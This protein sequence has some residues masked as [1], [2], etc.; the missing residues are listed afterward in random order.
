MDMQKKLELGEI[1]QASG[2]L[3]I[4]E[5]ERGIASVIVG[6]TKTVKEAGWEKTAL[7]GALAGNVASHLLDLDAPFSNLGVES[8]VGIDLAIDNVSDIAAGA[9]LASLAYK[10]SK[11]I[12]KASKAENLDK[13]LN[14]LMPENEEKKENEEV[15]DSTNALKQKIK[16]LE[17]QL[18][19]K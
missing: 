9:A 2:S 17:E 10:A 7:M 12:S 4:G 19:N 14:M 3:A 15:Q 1:L 13:L 5:A 8:L 18:L 6:V 16:E 11:N